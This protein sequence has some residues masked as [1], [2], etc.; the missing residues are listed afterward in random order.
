MEQFCSLHCGHFSGLGPKAY[1]KEEA[2]LK[3]LF[4]L[5]SYNKADETLEITGARN[6]ADSPK[7]IS[8]IFDRLASMLEDKSK[9]QIMLACGGT[10]ICYF[11]KNMW[12]LLCVNIPEDPFVDIH[13]VAS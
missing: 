6:I 3:G 7:A 9:G 13:Y 12:K 8:S 2:W 10:E 1:A 4:E 5:V 11:R